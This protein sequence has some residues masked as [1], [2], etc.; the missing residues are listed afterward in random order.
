MITNDNFGLLYWSEK[1]IL[2]DLPF[3]FLLS[4]MLLL[5][6]FNLLE[7]LESVFSREKKKENLFNLTILQTCVTFGKSFFNCPRVFFSRFLQ[8]SKNDDNDDGQFGLLFVWATYFLS[9]FLCFDLFLKKIFKVCWTFLSVE[10][11][12]KWIKYHRIGNWKKVLLDFLKNLHSKIKNQI[13]FFLWLNKTNNNGQ[14]FLVSVQKKKIKVNIHPW[15]LWW[16]VIKE[17]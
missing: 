12:Q 7:F 15:W 2:K 13:H 5:L 3:L 16:S 14:C 1:N 17:N 9:F 11:P 10:Y 8:I 6:I 4:L